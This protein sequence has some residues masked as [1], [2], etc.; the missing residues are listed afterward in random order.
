M[1]GWMRWISATRWSVSVN[2]MASSLATSGGPRSR[3]VASSRW[4]RSPSQD[5]WRSDAPGAPALV[6]RERGVGHD[7]VLAVGTLHTLHARI[8]EAVDTR[9][10]RATEHVPELVGT[11]VARRQDQY[12]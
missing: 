8:L 4:N 7:D 2:T 6:R 1:S 11:A 10:T 5:K 3:P 9:G 12:V